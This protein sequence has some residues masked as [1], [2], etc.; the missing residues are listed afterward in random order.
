MGH[1]QPVALEFDTDR[2]TCGRATSARTTGKRSTSSTAAATTAGAATKAHDPYNLN[3]CGPAGDFEFPL[4]VYSHSLGAAVTGGYVYHGA[5]I[6]PLRGVY[7][8]GDHV[9]RPP[10]DHRRE[11]RAV[12]ERLL[13]RRA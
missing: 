13:E 5:R 9:E 6:P 1:A 8:Y 4:A 11:P 2:A 7:L 3:G 12:P 10:V